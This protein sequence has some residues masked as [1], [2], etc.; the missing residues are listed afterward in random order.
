MKKSSF[1]EEL[2]DLLACPT[3][4]Q[5]LVYDSKKSV[6]ITEDGKKIYKIVDGIPRLTTE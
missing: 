5:N 1:N 2:L 6:L 3:T 4:G